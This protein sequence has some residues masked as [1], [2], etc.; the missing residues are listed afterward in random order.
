MTQGRRGRPRRISDPKTIGLLASGIR[1]EIVDTLEALGGEAEVAEI[2]RELGRPADGLYYHLD[3]LR[4]GGVLAVGEIDGVRRYRLEG[5]RGGMLQLDYRGGG[6]RAERATL[7]A[8]ESML[9]IAREDFGTALAEPDTVVDGTRRELWA[10]R[11][12]GWV[13]DAGLGEIN[14]LLGR[15]HELLHGPRRPGCD[16]LVSL[17]FVLA[18]VAAQ[19]TR[20]GS[21]PGGE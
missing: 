20:R 15:L 6:A 14:R 7:R 4:K 10:A 12:K 1:Q 19:P 9:K 16:R 5:V 13:D 2:A 3:L 18:P 8:V 17:C 11:K 21:E